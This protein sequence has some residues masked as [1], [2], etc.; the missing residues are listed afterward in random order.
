MDVEERRPRSDVVAVGELRDLLGETAV[1]IR[2]TGLPGD[3][4][5]DAAL[6]SFGRLAYDDEW[7]TIRP[8]DP[9]RVPDAVAAI[10]ALG[11]RVHAVDPG[12]RSLE[13]LFLGMVRDDE[14]E[15]GDAAP[16]ASASAGAGS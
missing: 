16:P 3:G 11:G 7:L 6:A 2:V 12:R 9:D 1:R 8:I 13:D 4:A 14:P 5:V 10:V 15:R